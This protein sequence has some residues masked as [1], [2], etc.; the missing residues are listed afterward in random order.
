M[1]SASA[2]ARLAVLVPVPDGFA[3]AMASLPLDDAEHPAAAEQKSSPREVRIRA[4][5]A[6]MVV[7]FKSLRIGK[8]RGQPTS[9]AKFVPPPAWTA[10]PHKLSS[11]DEE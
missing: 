4:V 9:K 10:S 6:M 3:G 11:S 7:P 8:Q 5:L 1:M 2:M